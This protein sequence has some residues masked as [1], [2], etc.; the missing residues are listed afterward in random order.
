[1]SIFKLAKDFC[2]K[3]WLLLLFTFLFSCTGFILEII[4]LPLF[5][6]KITTFSNDIIK[7]K[8][9]IIKLFCV[10]VLI[11]IC[12]SISD[13]L[14]DMVKFACKQF[15]SETLVSYEIIRM[16]QEPDTINIAQLY[17]TIEK[18]E[19]H[20]ANMFFYMIRILPRIVSIIFSI[21]IL[22]TLQ[23]SAGLITLIGYCIILCI[24]F[25]SLVF[26]DHIQNPEKHEDVLLDKINEDFANTSMIRSTATAIPLEINNIQEITMNQYTI[27]IKFSSSIHNK[28]ILLY[29]CIIIM[30]GLLLYISYRNYKNNLL[31]TESFTRIILSI[32]PLCSQINNVIFFLPK[33]SEC[34]LVLKHYNSPITTLYSYSIVPS[35]PIPSSCNYSFT[36]VIFSYPE[37][38]PLLQNFSMILPTGLIWLRG[39]SG[40]GK[41]TFIKLLLG[42]LSVQE[43]TI[44]LGDTNVT[45]SIRHHI[46][47][48]H[49]HAI[50]L[51]STTIYDNI[52]Y[53]ITDKK[54]YKI[55]LQELIKRYN[56]Y[57]L[58]GCKNGDESFLYNHV[59]KLGDRLSGGQRQMVH[60]LRCMMIEKSLYIMDE[61]L[62][63]LDPDTKAIVIQLLT[64][65][66]EQG[67]TIYIISHDT[68]SFPQ[69]HVLTF[70]K[71]QVPQLT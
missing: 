32:I 41:S 9:Y 69:Q 29:G 35:I 49:Q 23:I 65:M 38:P 56:L 71:G 44:Q 25:F 7:V 12:F 57:S 4:V 62:T 66:I 8:K 28:K 68:L 63:G 33:L 59:G 15:V 39:E 27:D 43:G 5:T 17:N 58:F 18:V 14:Y 61:P 21:I 55:R 52:M 46:M 2:K 34:I 40:S 60:L 11:Q 53:G 26:T 24:V 51:F 3:K 54:Q 42:T 20:M 37:Q 6:S 45:T 16:D 50:C 19:I 64:D 10:W 67:K 36:S 47:Y 22:F 31:S 13:K 70:V 1:M 30:S 48:I